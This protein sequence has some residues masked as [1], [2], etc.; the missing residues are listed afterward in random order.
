MGIIYC[1][2][3]AI[4]SSNQ[5]VILSEA[6]DLCIPA[7]DIDTLAVSNNSIENRNNDDAHH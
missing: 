4:E 2:C 6:K 7:C 3:S 5:F 1:N